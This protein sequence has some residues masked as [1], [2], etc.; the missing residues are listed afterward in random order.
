MGARTDL[1][2]FVAQRTDGT[3]FGG[4]ERALVAL[5]A[6]ER[7]LRHFAEEL[8]MPVEA[9]DLVL[10]ERVNRRGTGGHPQDQRQDQRGRPIDRAAG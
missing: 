8:L 6:G 3:L 9:A 1:S 10:V 2:R 5:G 7:S 4:D